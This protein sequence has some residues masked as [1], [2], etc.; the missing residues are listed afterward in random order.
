MTQQTTPLS[1][2]HAVNIIHPVEAGVVAADS[3]L[4]IAHPGNDARRYLLHPLRIGRFTYAPEFHLDRSRFDSFLLGMVREGVMHATIWDHEQPCRYDIVAG[5]IF[6]FDTYSRHEGHTGTMTRTSM[7]HFDGPSARLYYSR[8]IEA[9]GNVFP[10]PNPTL[11]EHSIDRLFDVYGQRQRQ[12]DLIGAQIL[13][14]LLTDLATRTCKSK[15]V[16]IPSVKDSLIFLDNH[17]R[18]NITVNMLARRSSLSPRQYLR[19]FRKLTGTTPYAY[20]TALRI[21]EASALLASTSMPIG[22]VADAIGYDNLSTFIRAFK[23]HTATTPM[24]YRAMRQSDRR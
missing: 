4:L 15:N 13:T 12:A 16:I 5:D 19:Q 22:H 17:Y 11:L 9:Q 21:N 23:R 1:P 18:E 24:Q 2:P 6:L 14:D 20:L 10:T 8:I 7:I 3:E